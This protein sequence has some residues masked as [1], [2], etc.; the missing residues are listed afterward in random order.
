MKNKKIPQIKK[1]ISHFL[2]SEE[3]S[4]NKKDA[5]KIGMGLLVLGVSMTGIMKA[6]PALGACSHS[7]HGSHGSH[8]SHSAHAS[9]A[10]HG[11]HSAHASHASHNSHAS[12]ASHASHGAHGSHGSD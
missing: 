5:T 11:S 7:A 1:D 10:S 8:G 12:H 4:I 3:G 2:S 6:D 9:H